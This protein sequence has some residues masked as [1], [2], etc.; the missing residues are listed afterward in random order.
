M[1]TIRELV[2]AR[3]DLRETADVLINA[4]VH[5]S[6]II[7]ALLAIPGS[8][9]ATSDRPAVTMLSS[10]PNRPAGVESIGAMRPTTGAARALEIREMW[11]RAMARAMSS[12]QVQTSAHDQRQPQA[13]NV[14]A[15]WDTAM[16]RAMGQQ[17]P[18]RRVA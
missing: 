15:L 10:A 11:D 3:P 6:D 13:P 8:P 5:A 18:Q 12:M 2:A 4:G 16:Q 17:V 14:T 7:R 9:G 1:T